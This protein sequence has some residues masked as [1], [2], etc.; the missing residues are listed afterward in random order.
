[1]PREDRRIIFEY[2]EVYKALYALAVQRDMKAL[3]PGRIMALT[4]SSEDKAVLDITIENPHESESRTVNFSQ[5]F[6]AAALML[7]CRGARIPIPKSGQKSVRIDDD[8][9]I[10][11]ILV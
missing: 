7:Y 4:P 11:R 2:D 3:P 1:M 8:T 9:V 5:D 10:L 6:L